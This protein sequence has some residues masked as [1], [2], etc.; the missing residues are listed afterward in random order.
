MNGQSRRRHRMPVAI[1]TV[2]C[3]T[4]LLAAACSSG[5]NSAGGSGGSSSTNTPGVTANSITIGATTPLTGPAAPGYSEIAPASDAY[6]KY[7]NAHGGVFG[8]KITYLIKN[9]QYDPSLTATLT[10]E[11]VLQDHI[12]ADV[13]PLGTPTFLAVKDFLNTEKVP[14]LFIESG[15]NCWSSPSLPLTF[16]WQPPYTVEGKL[17]GQYTTQHFSGQKVGYLTQDDEFGQ[18]GAKGLDQKIPS[19]D[20]VSR[21]TYTATPQAL[22][23]GLGSQ[24]SALKAAGATVVELFT[25]PA[26]TALTLLAAAEIG[27]HPQWIVTSVG[28]DPHTLSGLLSNFSKGKAGAALLDGMITNTYL[29]LLTDSSNPWVAGF[30][31]I[32]AAYDPGATWDGNTEYGL[33]LGYT[34]VQA[35]QATG[36]DLT[37]TGLVQ[38]LEQ[39]G[40]SFP[41]AGLVPLSY[42]TTDHYGFQGSELVQLSN[43]GQT[44]TALTHRL[45][46]TVSGPIAQATTPVS[47]PP[48]N[49]GS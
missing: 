29:P 22:A 46:A 31:K 40:A 45:T 19:S 41:G 39:K 24:V 1:T 43:S 20:V 11:L 49:F 2:L 5:T 26:A 12:F 42:S 44:L 18:D 32:L 4:A 6:F 10:R 23:N 16:G 17:L 3:A 48:A 38:A 28:S 13:G 21:Q 25:I 37:R 33:A 14:S 7:V 15:C 47:T 9:D 35:L 30:K 36:K 34:F 27:Y 8:R